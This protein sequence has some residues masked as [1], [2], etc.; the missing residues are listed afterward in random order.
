ME[1]NV[2]VSSGA[3]S[4]C[5]QAHQTAC[6]RTLIDALNKLPVD[7][8]EEMLPTRYYREEIRLIGSTE[9]CC[10]APKCDDMATITPRRG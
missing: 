3:T 9:N 1:C 7:G 4:R 10:T 8:E 5:E 6:E 2:C